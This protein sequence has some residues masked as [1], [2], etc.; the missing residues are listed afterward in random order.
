MTHRTTRCFVLALTLLLLTACSVAP[1]SSI[2]RQG[3]PLI[4]GPELRHIDRDYIDRYMCMQGEVLACTC[5]SRLAR[6]C[7]CKCSSTP[8]LALGLA[9]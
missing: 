3:P 6:E 5:A 7:L 9:R 2:S 1:Y 4:V 8:G